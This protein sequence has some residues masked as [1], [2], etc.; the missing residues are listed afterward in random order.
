MDVVME[1]G[2]EK[3]GSEV[4]VVEGEGDDVGDGCCVDDEDDAG[5]GCCVGDEDGGEGGGVDGEDE[6]GGDEEGDIVDGS[7]KSGF[8]VLGTDTFPVGETEGGEAVMGTTG[9]KAR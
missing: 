2:E 8:D 5:D 3:V 7:E 4:I 1:K 6:E 9:G